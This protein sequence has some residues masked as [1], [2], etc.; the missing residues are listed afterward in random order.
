M[1]N[2]IEGFLYID[3]YTYTTITIIQ[4]SKLARS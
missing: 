3:T 4:L 2:C 1:I